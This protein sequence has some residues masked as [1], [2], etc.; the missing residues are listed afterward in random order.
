MITLQKMYTREQPLCFFQLWGRRFKYIFGQ[1]MPVFSSNIYLF[2]DGKAVSYRHACLNEITNTLLLKLL[3]KD[4]AFIKKSVARFRKEIKK[5]KIFCKEV[6]PSQK[7][8]KRFFESLLV[9][10]QG[11]YMGY[12]IPPDKRFTEKDRELC[13]Q[14]RK[15]MDP[16]GPMASK[17]IEI[18]LNNFYPH[19]V[20][21]VQFI[22]LEEVL[23]DR[24]PDQQ[25]LMERQNKRII[26]VDDKI[27]SKQELKALRNKYAFEFEKPNK[28]SRLR[29]LKGQIVCGGK[30]RGR[31]R[32][33]QRKSQIPE[34]KKGE[35]LVTAMTTPDYLPAMHKAVAFITDEGGITCHA[36]IVAPPLGKP[37]IIGTKIATRMFKNGDLVEVDANRGIVKILSN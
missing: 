20:G 34:L 7:E 21:L 13:L 23:S 18:A 26:I 17:H 9:C 30:V 37:C 4:S 25:V 5:I 28:A 16:L 11:F 27:V 10:W 6:S 14:F 29:E 8:F 19:L 15:E 35:I 36:A 12:N 33:L 32:V 1:D 31:I 22:A 3:A 24:V 2:Q